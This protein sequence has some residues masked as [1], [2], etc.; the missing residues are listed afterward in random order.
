MLAGTPAAQ[1][2]VEVIRNLFLSHDL[3]SI[4]RVVSESAGKLIHAQGVTFVL[5]EDNQVYYADE[6][7]ISP[8]WK[9]C[10]FSA[11]GCI[12]GWS[13][14]HR[15]TVV[16][17]DVYSDDRIPVETYRP[18]FVKSLLI[19]PVRHSDP[20]G[21]IGAY[22]AMRHEATTDEV[23][24]LQALA[25]SAAIALANLELYEE[26]KRAKEAAECRAAEKEQELAERMK[27][28][29][30]LRESE[31]RFRAMAEVRPVAVII[32]RRSDGRILY[33]NEQCCHMF[34]TDIQ[35]LLGRATR[36]LY[37]DIND[38]T[39]LLELLSQHHHIENYELELKTTDG[40][41]LWVSA[42]IQLVTFQHAPSLLCT[43]L[44]ITDRKRAQATV[45]HLSQTFEVDVQAR[46]EAFATANKT[47]QALNELK[48]LEI[49]ER[50]QA[51]QALME[52]NATL[53]TQVAEQ[54]K[55]LM[56][57][58][59]ELRAL[60]L[61][62][63]RTEE[64]L[65]QELATHLH[66]DLA[67]MLVLGKMKL[68]KAQRVTRREDV[69]PILSEVSAYVEDALTYTR[70][71]MSDLRPA[72]LGDAS[73]LSMAIAWVAEKMQRHGL[74]VTINDEGSPGVLGDEIVMLA[75]Q[76]IQELLYNV[77]KHAKS[78]EALVSLR[79]GDHHIEATVQDWGIG[80]DPSRIGRPSQ[81]GGFGLFSLRERL[82]LLGGR[83]EV[84]SAAH[85]GTCVKV[86]IPLHRDAA[87]MEQ[88]ASEKPSTRGLTVNDGAPEPVK[89]YIRVLLADDHRMMR[90]GLSSVI[91][92]QPDMMVVGEASDG[93]AAI[94]LAKTLH[95]SVILMDI[96]MPQLN[97]IEATKKIKTEWPEIQV[98]GL[99]FLKEEKVR[100]LM[101]E[102]G[103]CAFLSKGESFDTLSSRIREAARP[104]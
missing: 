20:I 70:T 90:E 67:Q 56:M 25:D 101:Y 104:L 103:A 89:T 38:R 22:W 97:G 52:L 96:N 79:R 64:R 95:P 72:L 92:A 74:S 94:E 39:K 12:T 30:V 50:T 26:M 62:L 65:R 43:L 45:E 27:V 73:D 75:Y 77:L 86:I 49:I 100:M 28:E 32:S 4:M 7:A 3:R 11:H 83:F 81:D 93:M 66:D 98:I 9:G 10:R 80:F 99:T 46:S 91:N 6:Q 53:Q 16:I 54:T 47:F 19:V 78:K 29:S 85:K 63:S 31:E 17:P 69:L 102:A 40:A 82:E 37:K 48:S 2:L 58:Q 1:T 33:A 15:Q 21:A 5:R 71:L 60:A 88:C 41:P 44:D 35:G 59:Q 87:G 84:T 51:E 18:T 8:L 55:A 76:S 14:L 61:E 42:S 24:L 57:K 23:E 13:M 34:H 68:E 36:E